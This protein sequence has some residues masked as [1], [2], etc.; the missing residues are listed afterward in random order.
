MYGVC[1]Y[2]YN[3]IFSTRQLCQDVNV[4]GRFGN[5]SIPIFMVCW[6]FGITET[7]DSVMIHSSV[8]M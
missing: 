5:Y 3:K 7:D 4:F 1:L 8:F 6:W 2:V